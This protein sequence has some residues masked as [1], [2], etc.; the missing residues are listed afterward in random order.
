MSRSGSL[1]KASIAILVPSVSTPSSLVPSA[2]KVTFS[3]LSALTSLRK[4]EYL[5]EV[6]APPGEGL[7]SGT[8]V[9]R[10]AAAG[11]MS[12]RADADEAPERAPPP[13]RDGEGEKAS[14]DVRR[15][16]KTVATANLMVA[17]KLCWE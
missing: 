3:T 9:S 10:T 14:V 6:G 15:R 16:V 2:E 13:A 12:N 4:S 7:S 1:G 8:V 17:R 11:G 5:T